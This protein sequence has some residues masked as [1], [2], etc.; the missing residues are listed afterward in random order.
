MSHEV[1]YNDDQSFSFHLIQKI[2]NYT[3]YFESYTHAKELFCF[4]YVLLSGMHFLARSELV[5]LQFKA[6]TKI[7]SGHSLPRLKSTNYGALNIRLVCKW[8]DRTIFYRVTVTCF[9]KQGAMIVYPYSQFVKIK[10][11][12]A[13]LKKRK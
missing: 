3:S 2:P 9:I 11:Y 4:K 7:A 1:F 5:V 10:Y 6:W 13:R 8:L 12:M